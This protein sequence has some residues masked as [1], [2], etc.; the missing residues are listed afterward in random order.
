LTRRRRRWSSARRRANNLDFVD[1][2]RIA[3]LPLFLGG[4]FAQSF[5]FHQETFDVADRPALTARSLFI[6]H[7][8]ASKQKVHDQSIAGANSTY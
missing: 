3:R 2:L 6:G 4:L 8:E 5:D 1:T 7:V